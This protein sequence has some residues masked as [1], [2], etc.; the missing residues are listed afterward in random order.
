MSAVYVALIVAFG[1]IATVAGPIILAWLLGRQRRAEK[2]EDY[3]RQDAVAARVTEAADKAETV[4]KQAAEA[5]R[6]LVD[7]NAAAALV[8]AQTAAVTNDKLDQIHTLVNS[9]LTAAIEAQLEAT[10]EQLRMMRDALAG[11][12]VVP[13]VEAMTRL[14]EKIATIRASL[15]DRLAQ[16]KL[17][18]EQ[19]AR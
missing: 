12:T 18:Q 15:Y 19:I 7:S 1:T 17:A 2:R 11:Q 16:T 14:E 13:S 8:A 5:A 4:A 6:L 3:A 10:I 9:T